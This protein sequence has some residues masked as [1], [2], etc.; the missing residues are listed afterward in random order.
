MVASVDP[1]LL[2]EEIY[3][4]H[5]PIFFQSGP[6]FFRKLNL[7]A[8]EPHVTSWRRQAEP[9]TA[10]Q[11]ALQYYFVLFAGRSSQ[12]STLPLGLAGPSMQNCLMGMCR[13][14][15][16]HFHDLIDCK[17]VAFSTRGCRF[18]AELRVI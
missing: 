7:T 18:P 14:M 10:V 12:D 17:A 6:D 8:N 9:D 16:S 2:L 13:C 3:S 1:F 5:L 15:G 11:P 4:F